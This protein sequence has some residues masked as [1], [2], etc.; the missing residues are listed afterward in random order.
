V[1]MTLTGNMIFTFEQYIP[2]VLDYILT[3][4]IILVIV[5]AHNGNV[6]LKVKIEIFPF[7]L[8]C[9]CVPVSNFVDGLI[10]VPNSPIRPDCYM[11]T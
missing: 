4:T 2:V 7:S 8:V 11:N 5:Y 9:H 1:N 10:S 6:F 3:Y